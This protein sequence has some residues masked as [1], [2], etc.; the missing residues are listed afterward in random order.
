MT[1]DVLVFNAPHEVQYHI[2]PLRSNKTV[3]H[4]V[5]R[6]L[7]DGLPVDQEAWDQDSI[8]S[9]M[10]LLL[11]AL[12]EDEDLLEVRQTLIYFRASTSG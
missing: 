3:V 10:V 6:T 11:K 5:L 2:I 1:L 9:K 4:N 7:A 8:T 12:D